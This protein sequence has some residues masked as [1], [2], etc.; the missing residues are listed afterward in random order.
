M[1]LRGWSRGTPH[2]DNLDSLLTDPLDLEVGAP[3]ALTFL[4]GHPGHRGSLP[5]ALVDP[6]VPSFGGL[7]AEEPLEL[8]QRSPLEL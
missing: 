1:K 8:P 2:R 7:A 4:H 6:Q 3:P 5:G